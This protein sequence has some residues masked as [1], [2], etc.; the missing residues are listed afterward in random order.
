MSVENDNGSVVVEDDVVSIFSGGTYRLEG[1]TDRYTVAVSA[2]DDD[3]VL[4]LS[5][6]EMI[7][8]ETNAP[9]AV[10]SADKVDIVLEEGALVRLLDHRPDSIEET[11]D[12][13][14]AALYAACDMTLSG[15]GTLEIEATYNNGIGSKDDL[16]I[17]EATITVTAANHG[18]KGSD[19]LTIVS[20][21]FHV[22]A[23]SGDGLKTSNSDVSSKGNQRGT[24]L[25]LGGTLTIH[26]ARDGIDAA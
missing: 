10:L 15:T 19:S 9:I 7:E 8:S 20:G 6:L 25:I 17:A 24:I 11:D 18:I 2:S 3:V 21:T 16:E 1:T 13:P 23:V 26:A 22:T 14:N 4:V 5:N 12:L